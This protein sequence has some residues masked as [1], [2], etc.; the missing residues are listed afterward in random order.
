[1]LDLH[2][3]SQ[4][5]SLVYDASMDIA[6]WP[7]TLALLAKVFGGR[8]AQISVASSPHDIA[9]IKVWG[10]TDDELALFI[11]RYVALTPT[12]PRAGMMAAQYK[13][14]HCRQVVSDEVL[15]SSAMYKEALGPGGVEYSMGFTV[16]V[17][18]D[19]MCFL[20]VM[21]GPDHAPFTAGDCAD[22]SCLGPHVARAVTMYGAFQ[23]CREELA[24]VKALLDGVPLG[25]M[26]VDD[27]GLKVA[28]SAARKLL[29]EGDAVH[30][31][32]GRL[33]GATRRADA[34]LRDAVEEARSADQ[35]I[36]LALPIDNAQPMR[37]VI[38]RLQPASAGMLGVP[39]EAV[40][41][42]LTDPRKP[43][44]TP[45]EVLQRLF[46]LTGREASVLRILVEGVDLQGAAARLGISRETVR[47]HVKRI[48]DATGVRR[49]AELVRMVLSSPAWIAG[50]SG[51]P[52]TT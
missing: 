50:P 1:V 23:R 7:D 21:R 35:P 3:F 13:A 5:V 8:G 28:N 6:R 48:M 26:V 29:D 2:D 16:P 45:E 22:F 36:G 20:S 15:R 42:Y 14:M 30:L 19:M 41:L 24:T 31:H 49:Q 51:S 18:P 32:N 44:E 43:V 9:F 11:P 25:M 4:A 40:A 47:D 27:G 10:W 46:G 38:R 33:R 52:P 12:D 34:D 37:A 39:R 17:V